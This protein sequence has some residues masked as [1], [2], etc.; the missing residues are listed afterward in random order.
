[1]HQLKRTKL[2]TEKSRKITK[3]NAKVIKALQKSLHQMQEDPF[4]KSL[5]THKVQSKR[6][7]IRYSNRVTGDIRII[8]DFDENDTVI[9]IL[10]DIG[11]HS[12]K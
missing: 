9:L 8:W 6:D 1:M 10:F 11:G 2:F 4:Y 12:R 5:K 7:G 3:G